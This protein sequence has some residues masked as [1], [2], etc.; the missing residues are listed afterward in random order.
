[1]EEIDVDH[2]RTF[3]RH[4]DVFD[5][6]PSPYGKSASSSGTVRTGA[7]MVWGWEWHAQNGQQRWSP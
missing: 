7:A 1:M 6:T 5:I 3:D 2:L 4:F